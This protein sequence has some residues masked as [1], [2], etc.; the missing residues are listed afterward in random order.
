MK[1]ARD[2]ERHRLALEA[3]RLPRFAGR[4]AARPFV[5]A[6]EGANGAGKTTVCRLLSRRL[7]A[8][9]CL[10]TAEAWFS[11]CFKTRMI[12]DASW[13]ASAMFFRKRQE[14]YH[15]DEPRLTPL[16]RHG[17]A[18]A[19]LAGLGF[20]RLGSTSLTSWFFMEGKRPSTSVRYSCGL[21]PRRRQL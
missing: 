6:L 17:G 9:A 4:D 19:G 10:G 18:Y 14:R 20:Q 2:K 5:V 21:M 13:F 7:G 15:R 8:P 11:D 12:R 3:L 1:P 16:Q